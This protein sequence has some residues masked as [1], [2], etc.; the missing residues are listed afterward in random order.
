M[1]FSGEM[2]NSL[3][4]I[5]RGLWT[6]KGW[7]LLSWMVALTTLHWSC[8]H[9]LLNR[10]CARLVPTWNT[11]MSRWTGSCIQLNLEVR[12]VRPWSFPWNGEGQGREEGRPPHLQSQQ[13]TAGQGVLLSPE[14]WGEAPQLLPF[15]HAL[16]LPHTCLFSARQTSHHQQLLHRLSGPS[17]CPPR[18]LPK[19]PDSLGIPRQQDPLTQQQWPTEVPQWWG[20]RFQLS[21]CLSG[22]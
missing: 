2:I 12:R 18:L 5:L 1:S 13:S 6:W 3:C 15:V 4:R 10:S 19:A 17:T 22:R 8:P 7:D 9:R 21:F 11:G 20:R 16:L 14:G